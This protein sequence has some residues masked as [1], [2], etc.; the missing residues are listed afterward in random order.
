MERWGNGKAL[1]WDND[2]NIE[3][4]VAI[5]SKLEACGHFMPQDWLARNDKMETVS[6][7]PIES[8]FN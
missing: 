3:P 6:Q 2:T 7:R 4:P 1:P 8:S 5:K